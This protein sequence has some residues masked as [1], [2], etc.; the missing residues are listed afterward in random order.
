M[1]HRSFAASGG[2]APFNRPANFD[3]D[4][5]GMPDAWETSLG[6][7]P[8]VANH[9]ADFDSDGYTDLEEYIN[10]LAEWPCAAA[11]RLQRRKWSLRPDQQLGHQV[12]ARRCNHHQ[13]RD[14]AC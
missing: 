1:G 5:D 11:D 14:G 2:V 4:Q 13:R 7:N 8:A 10:E 3:T 12:A 6:L 9:N